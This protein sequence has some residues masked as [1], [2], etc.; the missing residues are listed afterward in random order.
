LQLIYFLF[1]VLSSLLH[2]FYNFLMRKKGGSQLYLNA[3]FTTA[4]LISFIAVLA[5]RG[6]KDLPWHNV[7]YIYAAS[8]FYVLYQVFVNKAYREGGNI[9]TTYPLSVL[10]PLFIPVWA[11]LLL[12]EKISLLTAAGILLLLL[13]QLPSR[14][15]FFHYGKY[16]PFSH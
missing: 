1:I 9:S 8:V 4:T 14:W 16:G 15:I 13:G 12:G 11:M 10:S 6:Y 2:A 3:V 7:P 5:V